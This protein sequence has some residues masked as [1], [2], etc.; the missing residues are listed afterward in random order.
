[1]RVFRKSASATRAQ[2]VVCCV[3]M[4]MRYVRLFGLV[5][6]NPHLCT[7]HCAMNIHDD[8]HVCVCGCASISGCVPGDSDISATSTT[9]TRARARARRADEGVGPGKR[10]HERTASPHERSIAHSHTCVVRV[11]FLR[12]FVHTT[13]L[14]V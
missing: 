7:R 10:T 14:S 3:F 9:T 8:A 13:L 4:R 1:M 11:A 5:C 6:L 2:I 12:A